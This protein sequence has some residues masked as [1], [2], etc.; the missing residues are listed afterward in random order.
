MTDSPTITLNDGRPMPRLGLGVFKLPADET[1]ALV[2]QAIDAGFRAVDTAAIY[3]NE[4]GVGAAVRGSDA[5]IFVTSKLW[6]DDFG[7]DAALKAFDASMARLRLDWLDLYLIHWPAPGRGLAIETWKALVRLRDEGRVRSIG[8]SN[9]QPEHLEQIIEATGVV[10]AVN[11]IELHVS[12][13]QR[14]LRQVHAAHGIATTSWSPLGRGD[15]LSD[16]AIVAIAERL[17]RTPAQVVIRWH[18]QSGLI[19]IPKTANPARLPE[20]FDVF[21]F[22]LTPEDMAAI[23]ALDRAD[24]RFGPDPDRFDG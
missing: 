19:V 9:F 7:Y 13:Q 17:G 2:G 21:G 11:Q 10:P 1:E 23:E 22:D 15:G 12:F 14:A 3:R 4:E 20:N 6:I 8:V 18:L 16:P 5:T 24:G